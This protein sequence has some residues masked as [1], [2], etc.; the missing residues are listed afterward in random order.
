MKVSRA[1]PSFRLENLAIAKVKRAMWG[2]FCLISLKKLIV[3]SKLFGLFSHL[4]A[5]LKMINVFSLDKAFLTE[6]YK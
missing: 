6:N 2:W 5:N 1:T 4:I 3:F